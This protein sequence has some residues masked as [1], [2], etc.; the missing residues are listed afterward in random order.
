MAKKK[1]EIDVKV[2]DKGTTKKLALE[3]KKAGEGLDQTAKSARTADRN[4]KGVA[5]TSANASK[6][7]SKMSQGMGGLVGAYATFAASVFALSAAFNFLKNAADI[8]QL[9]ASQVSFAQNTGVQM[10]SLTTQLREASKG[11]L[12]FQAAAEASA[13]GVAKG[14]SAGQMND[15]ASGAL[16]VSNVLGRNFADSFDRLVRGISKAEPELLDELGITLRLETATKAYADSLGVAADSLSTADKSQAV[17]LETMKQLEKVT[18]GQE[19]VENPFVKLGATFSDIAK[20]VSGAILPPLKG[21]ANFLNDNAAAA[22]LFFGAIGISIVKNMPFIGDMKSAITDFFDSQDQKAINAQKELENYKRKLQE[23]KETTEQTRARGESKVQAGARRATKRSSSKV[24]QRAAEGTMTGT[25]KANL[26]KALVSYETQMK[27]S[28]KVTTGI[29]KNVSKSV[30]RD[31]ARGMKM[32]EA[33]TKQSAGGM[34]MAIKRFSLETKK[35]TAV[36]RTKLAPAMMFVGNAAKKMGKAM[37]MAMKATVILGVIQMVYDLIMTI[38][39]APTKILGAVGVIIK[40]IISL[41]QGFMNIF[42]A[43]MNLVISGLQ[44]IPGLGNMEK[45]EPFDFSGAKEGVDSIVDSLNTKMGLTGF[46]EARQASLADTDRL[47]ALKDDAREGARILSQTLQG[48][49]FD[50]MNTFF[51]PAK[52]SIAAANAIK[53]SNIEQLMTDAL[54]I[55]D[56][57]KQEKAFETIATQFKDMASLSPAIAKAFSE[58]NFTGE[59]GL[60]ELIGDARRMTNNI[61]GANTKLADMGTTLKGATATGVKLFVEDL[62]KM[63]TA[64]ETSAEKLGLTTDIKDKIDEKFA[65]KGGV[66]AYINLLTELEG[67]ATTLANRKNELAIDKAGAV[68]TPKLFQEQQKADFSYRASEIALSEKQLQL[69]QH[70]AQLKSTMSAE[71]K[72][73]HQKKVEMLNREIDLA[74]KVRDVAEEQTDSQVRMGQKIGDSMASSMATAFQSIIDGSMSAK[75]AFAQMGKSI[76]SMMAKIVAEALAMQAIK[77]LFGGTAFGDLLGFADGGIAS[78]GK[79]VSGYSSGGIARGS[80]QGYPAI[81][82]G[83]EAVVPLPNGKS[84]PVEM[85]SSGGQQNIVNVSV[86]SDGQMQSTQVSGEDRMEELGKAVAAAVQKEL[87]NQKRSGG[88]L[89][90]VGAA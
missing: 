62:N 84:I 10:A 14:F 42:V 58:K 11:M 4:T 17:Y 47:N 73:N 12:D 81:L 28:G 27:K 60:K 74:E 56:P 41:V 65:E 54:A 5:N 87:Q 2:D 45:I 68:G 1:V 13:I 57:K 64:A 55:E 16:A 32:A 50:P 53:T 3:S 26:K 9:E 80:R 66:D 43:G 67:R 24:L 18:S 7:F 29:F 63:A 46:E 77:G 25:D 76:L 23:I 72:E 89:S 78:N 40:G 75:E 15:I 51:D 30:V 49:A 44:K 48:D 39:N 59:G 22:A 88:I 34:R 61:E 20:A 33:K 90:P 38:V 86:S 83:T 70:N 8:A 37:N 82:H 21:L 36:L 85:K 79:K 31:I 19:G 69:D 71:E 6:N 52:F 35:A